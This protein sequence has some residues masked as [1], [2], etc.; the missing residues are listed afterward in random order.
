MKKLTFLILT[1]FCA[2]NTLETKTSESEN[3]I[4]KSIKSDNDWKTLTTNSRKF[5]E[6]IINSNYDLGA[7][8]WKDLAEVSKISGISVSDLQSMMQASKVAGQRLKEKLGAFTATEGCATCRRT[9]Q[10]N[11]AKFMQT[12]TE[13]K[14]DPKLADKFYNNLVD[15]GPGCPIVFYACVA[16]CAATIEFFPL[17]LACCTVCL[18]EF[19]DNP[20]VSV[21]GS[22]A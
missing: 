17:Y 10:E 1:I 18:C 7:I 20:P 12:I 8:D 2:C 11:I 13:L 15:E 6:A 16:T 14:K 22:V 21:C 4:T 19:C 5:T 9:E 3:D